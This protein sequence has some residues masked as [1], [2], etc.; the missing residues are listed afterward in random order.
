MKKIM[1]YISSWVAKLAEKAK[2]AKATENIE[3]YESNE[4]ESEN[5]TNINKIT[6]DNK[7]YWAIDFFKFWIIWLIVAYLWFVAY[8]VID[9]I[10][11]MILWYIL[12][13]AIESYILWMIKKW[14]NRWLAILLSYLWLIGIILAGIL[15]I[16]PFLAGQISDIVEIFLKYFTSIQWYISQMWVVW[17]INSLDVPEYIK[18]YVKEFARDPQY[19]D[20]LQG[21]LLWSID[22]IVKQWSSYVGNAW[23]LVLWTVKNFASAIFQITLTFT[24]AVLFSIDQENILS[25]INK[26]TDSRTISLKI[27]KIY[28]KIWYWLKSQLLLC[29]FIFVTVYIWLLILE[30]FWISVPN[31]LSLALISWLTEIIPYIWPFIWA[32]PGILVWSISE[33]WVWFL[34]VTGM[35]FV[36]QWIENNVFIPTLM[37]KTLGVSPVLMF[38]CMLFLGMIMWVTGIIMAIPISI[39][40]SVMAE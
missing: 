17:Y 21:M 10:Y 19:I 37:N 8:G 34:V 5:I 15:I 30:V 3:I 32:V 28:T 18:F 23:I 29:L 33:W 36:I 40:I 16:V 4:I 35:Y 11:L 1:Q 31:K 26:V 39:I 22:G 6:E 12:S 27:K 13:V 7:K 20:T 9:T 38:I 14:I 25:Y 2:G 24:A